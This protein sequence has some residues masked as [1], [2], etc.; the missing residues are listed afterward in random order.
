MKKVDMSPEA[1]TGRMM[2]LDQM[3]EL[4][5][6]LKQSTFGSVVERAEVEHALDKRKASSSGQTVNG[7][8]L[9]LSLVDL[10]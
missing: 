7:L 5:V 1:V 3:W 2:M 10:R 9:D 8:P 4:S 6:A